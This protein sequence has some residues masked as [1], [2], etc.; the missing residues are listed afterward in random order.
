[1]FY[2][3]IHKYS[4]HQL[5]NIKAICKVR[6]KLSDIRFLELAVGNNLRNAQHLIAVDN[7]RTFW[8]E[9]LVRLEQSVTTKYDELIAQMSDVSGSTSKSTISDATPSTSCGTSV[10]CQMTIDEPQRENVEYIKNTVGRALT[11]GLASVTMNQPHDPINYLANFLIHYRNG[12]KQHEER[13]R[14]LDEIIELRQNFAEDEEDTCQVERKE[15]S[16]VD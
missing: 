10:E 2:E 1:M 4:T 3:E 9:N 11:L 16:E 6:S 7:A 14:E 13:E 5:Q 8:C 12:E 15:S